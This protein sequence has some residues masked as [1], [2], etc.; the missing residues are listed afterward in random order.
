MDAKYFGGYKNLPLAGII[1]EPDIICFSEF[2][3]EVLS[4]YNKTLNSE[5]ID[6]SIDAGTIAKYDGIPFDR[7]QISLYRAGWELEKGYTSNYMYMEN[8]DGDR[9][10]W[11]DLY[12]SPEDYDSDLVFKDILREIN[13]FKNRDLKEYLENKDD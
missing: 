9:L 12:Y 13:N 2:V 7:L 3:E 8:E 4:Y 10:F 5:R 6:T 11:L 1:L